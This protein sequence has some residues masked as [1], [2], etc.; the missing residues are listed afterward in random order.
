MHH[1]SLLSSNGHHFTFTSKI[2]SWQINVFIVTAAGKAVRRERHL[3]APGQD[4]GLQDEGEKT[5][6][7]VL[8]F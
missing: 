2:I 6:A 7:D 5:K 4:G 3:Q 8:V 1:A